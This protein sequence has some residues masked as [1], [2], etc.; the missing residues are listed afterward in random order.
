M[1]N[2]RIA[3]LLAQKAPSAPQR[4]RSALE[5]AA[6]PAQP[7]S[8]NTSSDVFSGLLAT[9]ETL[10][11]LGLSARRAHALSLLARRGPM[12]AKDLGN[13]IFISSAGMTVVIDSLEK[14]QLITLERSP[15]SDRRTVLLRISQEG[16]NVMACL[17]ALTGLGMASGALLRLGHKTN[18]QSR[19][20]V[21]HKA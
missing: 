19:L 7:Q 12:M 6:R 9:L 17:T 4:P 2:S 18:G 3:T 10:S 11:R 15:S 14:H 13:A 8:L 20:E 1:S 16:R 21:A 5:E